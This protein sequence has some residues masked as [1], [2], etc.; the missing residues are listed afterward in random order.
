MRH[1]LFP[2]AGVDADKIVVLPEAIDDEVVHD[3]PILLAHRGVEG[4]AILQFAQV[5]GDHILQALKGPRSPHGHFSHVRDIKQTRRLS[6]RLMLSDDP[7]ELDGHLPPRERHKTSALG[8]LEVI[9][10]STF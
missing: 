1:V 5:V 4:T 7:G 3:A 8:C 9:K 2:T 10:W 6:D